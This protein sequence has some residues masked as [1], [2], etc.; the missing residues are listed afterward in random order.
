MQ[1][2]KKKQIEGR[3]VDFFIFQPHFVMSFKIQV[4]LHKNQN[5]NFFIFFAGFLLLSLLRFFLS[6]GLISLESLSLKI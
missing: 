5:G 4:M 6:I 1:K 2:L 3:S